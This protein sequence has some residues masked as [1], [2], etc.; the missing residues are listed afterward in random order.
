TL[1][2]ASGET[3]CTSR[4]PEKTQ[5]KIRSVP[6]YKLLIPAALAAMALSPI[7]AAQT[8]GGDNYRPDL[9][10][11]D[12]HWFIAG[13]VGRTD[14]GTASRFGTGDFNVF[15][16]RDGRRTGYGLAGGYRWKVSPMWGLG[17]EGGYTDLGNLEVRNVFRDD[18]VDQREDQ[19]ALRGWH[20]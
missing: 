18:S 4:A 7:A 14:G 11:G 8:R 17:I 1:N 20:V 6:M 3:R 2:G 13:N 10:T 19:N 16:S 9:Q 15:E 12:G 5:Q